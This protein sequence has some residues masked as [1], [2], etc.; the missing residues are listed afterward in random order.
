[1]QGGLFLVT[2]GAGFLGINL[3]RHL[4]ARGHAVRS[5]DVSPFDYP[6]RDRVEITQGDIRDRDAVD[7]AM[8]GVDVVFHCAAALP[9]HREQEI[10]SCTVDGTRNVLDSAV[11]HGVRRVVYVSST[12]VYGVPDHHPLREGDPLIGVGPYGEAKIRAEQLCVEVRQHGLCVPVLRPKTFVGPERLGVFAILYEWAYEGHHFPIIGSGRNRYQLLDVE[13][14][15][16]ACYL[17]ATSPAEIANDTFNVGAAEFRTLGED[18]QAVLDYAG[19]GKKVIPV[20]AAPAIGALRLLEALRLSPLYRWV[21]ETASTDSYVS[22]D[23]IRDRLGF[24]PQYSNQDALI[25]NYRWYV[26]HRDAIGE[27]TGV[28]HRVPWRQGVLRLAKAFF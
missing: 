26:E 23:R 28:T 15:C 17:C 25:R 1:M 19:H 20:P 13:D 4:L 9:L 18:F 27:T 14:L 12:A 24:A 11:R 22:I 2:G 16:A 5:L 10:V 7:R 8:S 6:E 3:I 21:Y